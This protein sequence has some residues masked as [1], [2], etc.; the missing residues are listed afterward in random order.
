MNDENTLNHSIVIHEKDL[1][2]DDIQTAAMSPAHD[3][4]ATKALNAHATSM[5]PPPTDLPGTRRLEAPPD[6]AQK[7]PAR[8]QFHVRETGALLE[9]SARAPLTIGRRNTTMPVDIDLTEFN[10]I[11]MGISRNHVRI[12]PAGNM[13]M[14]VDLNSIN[15]T[16]LNGVAMKANR[17]YELRD[18]DILKTGRLHLRVYFIY[19]K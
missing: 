16:T 19:G 17:A 5:L 13:L 15:G 10:A 12:Q 3:A 9:T 2:P 14:A 1:L 18:G 11:E 6:D 7:L 8:I 4:P